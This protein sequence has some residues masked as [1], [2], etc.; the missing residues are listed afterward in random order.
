MKTRLKTTIAGIAL[1]IATLA[2]TALASDHIDGPSV[3]ADA[4][5]DITDL[6]AWVDGTNTV[7]ALNVNPSATAATQFSNTIQ[8]VLHTSSAAS[9]GAT[10]STPLVIMCTFDNAA[11]QNIS[12]WAGS[13]YVHG[14][15]S[16]TTG[17][18]S[19]DGKLKV[20]AGLRDDSFFFNLGG[21]H[22]AETDVEAAT[23]ITLDVAGCPNN[24]S[25][26]TVTALDKDLG[27]SNHGADTKTFVVWTKA[28]QPKWHRVAAL[29][30]DASSRKGTLEGASVPVESFDFKITAEKWDEP[31]LPSDFLIASQHVN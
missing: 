13:E 4:T 18:A 17:L 5:T 19:T 28:K 21:F 30:Y 8:Y 24:L 6:Y 23:G 25:S 14:N 22:D 3:K 26:G 29:K 10:T 27:G 16:A 31:E 15:A 7:F 20:F 2:P 1:G 12:C 9:F 11:T